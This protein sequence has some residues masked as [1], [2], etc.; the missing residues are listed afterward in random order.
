[1]GKKVNENSR[2]ASPKSVPIHHKPYEV[3]G[4]SCSER[5]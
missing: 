2:D 5:C 3:P 1:M 4:P